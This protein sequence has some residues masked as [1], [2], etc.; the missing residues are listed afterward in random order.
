MLFHK[1]L[2]NKIRFLAIKIQMKKGLFLLL[3]LAVSFVKLDAQTPSIPKYSEVKISS[4]FD[5]LEQTLISVNAKSDIYDLFNSI[6]VLE[7]SR[8]ILGSCKFGE[9]L[10][11]LDSINRII[12]TDNALQICTALKTF[13]K[14]KNFSE[15][16]EIVNNLIEYSLYQKNCKIQLCML[17]LCIV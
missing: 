6:A 13:E 4:N 3:F 14:I 11:L 15:K 5:S 17:I 2:K 8:L 9:S 16:S 7:K 12:N 10:I 1:F